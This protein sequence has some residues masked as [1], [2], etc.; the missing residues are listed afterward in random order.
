MNNG[1]STLSFSDFTWSGIYGTQMFP[2]SPDSGFSTNTLTQGGSCSA[3]VGSSSACYVLRWE[4]F[5]NP[6]AGFSGDTVWQIEGI[7]NL[8]GNVDLSG[9]PAVPIP[10]AVWLF[11]S[12]LLGLVGVARRKRSA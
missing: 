7:A 4:H 11:G 12:G 3:A 9:A 2:L 1:D 6:Q 10:A 5:I 8:D